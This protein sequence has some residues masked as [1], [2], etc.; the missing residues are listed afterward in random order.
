MSMH[1]MERVSY[2]K[3][4]GNALDNLKQHQEAIV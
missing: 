4:L 3:Y 2:Y 1:I